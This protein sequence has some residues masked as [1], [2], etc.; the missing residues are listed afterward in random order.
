MSGT[1]GISTGTGNRPEAES[2]PETSRTPAAPNPSEQ[3]KLLDAQI[4]RTPAV[5]TV[6]GDYLNPESLGWEH[7][8]PPDVQHMQQPSYPTLARPASIHR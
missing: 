7:F 1:A 6:S 5:L 4:P 8:A 2:G 3:Y